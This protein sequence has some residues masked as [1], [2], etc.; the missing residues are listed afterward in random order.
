[1][2]ALTQRPSALA[3]AATALAGTPTVPAALASALAEAAGPV[4]LVDDF[5]ETG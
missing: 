5:T 4:L 2:W 3:A 1:M